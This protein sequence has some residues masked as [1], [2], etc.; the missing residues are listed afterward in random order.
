[1]GLRRNPGPFCLGDSLLP[2]FQAINRTSASFQRSTAFRQEYE[3]TL[4]P[5]MKVGA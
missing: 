1:M 3:E 4:L 5:W 2:T